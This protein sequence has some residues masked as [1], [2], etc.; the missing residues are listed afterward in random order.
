MT[1]ADI[2][3]PAGSGPFKGK[4]R[5][6]IFDLKIKAK[7]PFLLNDGKNNLTAVQG[8][9]WDEKTNT[10]IA[11]LGSKTFT[12]SLKYIVKDIDFGGQ[13]TKK[14]EGGEAAGTVANKDVEVLSEA[15]FCYYFDLEMENKL[16]KY[17]P[18]VWKTITDKRSLEAWCKK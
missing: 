6:K 14:D 5:K 18:Q 15:F 7:S 8:V 1:P 12:T 2:A 13:P 16:S 11:K 4:P 9:K 17:S 3:K 10:L